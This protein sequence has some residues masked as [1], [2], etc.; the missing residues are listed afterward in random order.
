MIDVSGLTKLYGSF[1][2]VQ[3]LSFRVAA[4][5]VLG[6]VGPN[7]AGKTTTLR[8][9]AGIVVPS[10]GRIRIAGIDLAAD[11]RGAKRALAFVPDEPQLFDYLTVEE[12]LCFV[13]RL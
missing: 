12:P 1:P 7:G 11:P 13:A 6:L 3:E 8:A 2:A 4:G 5:E 10:A 9:L